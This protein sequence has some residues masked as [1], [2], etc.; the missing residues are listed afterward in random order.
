MQKRNIDFLLVLGA[1]IIFSILFYAYPPYYYGQYYK[2]LEIPLAILLAII[3][4]ATV[5]L[6]YFRHR[7]ERTA[8]QFP[9]WSKLIN[10]IAVLF[11]VFG[12]GLFFYSKYL[13]FPRQVP[14]DTEAIF[15]TLF[16]FV[17]AILGSIILT[18]K[19]IFDK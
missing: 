14:I 3:P 7:K 18:L 2:I 19:I 8:M 4:L 9:L 15:Y 17:L 16:G 1:I 12:Y 10:I 11:M 13:I 5:L 6:I